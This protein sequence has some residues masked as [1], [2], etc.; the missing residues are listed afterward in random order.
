MCKK[1]FKNSQPFGKKLTENRRGSGWLTLY[2]WRVV[3]VNPT[4]TSI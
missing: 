4:D 1:L 3:V 2:R